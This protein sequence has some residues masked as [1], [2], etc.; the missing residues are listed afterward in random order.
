MNKIRYNFKYL[1]NYC[2]QNN[3]ELLKDYSNETITIHSKIY[4]KCLT[5]QCKT[6][7]NKVFRYILESG[8][9]C[10]KCAR[11]NG[12]IKLKETTFK[13][14]GVEYA[15]QAKEIKE[16]VKETNIKKFGVPCAL[17]SKEVREKSNK[18]IKLKYGVDNVSQNN[19][20]KE[21]KKET[22]FKNFGVECS[23]YSLETQEKIKQSYINNYGVDNPFKSEEIKE[24]IK[25]TN[26]KKFGVEN[27][28]QSK[29]LQLKAQETNL[30]NY[31]VKYV[32]QCSEIM[33]KIIKNSYKLKEYN[34]SS[35][36]IIKCQGY[37]P[38]ALDE[39][40][41]KELIN[42]DDIVTG[43]KN[44]PKIWYT[45]EQNI[46][47]RHYVDIFIPS[48]NRCIEVKSTWT[49]NIKKDNIFLKQQAGKDLGYKYEIWVYNAKGERVETYL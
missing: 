37:E 19:E 10:K 40:L 38:L 41:Q 5:S 47:H 39:L 42:E 2:N 8:A 25:E 31:G 34:L 29:E 30:K 35:G 1:Q 17:Q 27:P 12:Y 13:R 28:M 49:I 14:Y 36:K 33:D 16:K 43:A 45:D 15:S 3:I 44:V 11:K 48:Q 4:C 9:Y 6:F 18:T 20:I 21:K 32:T 23:F 26:I 22:C 7:I 46:K 24:Q